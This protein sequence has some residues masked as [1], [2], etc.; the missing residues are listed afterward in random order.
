MSDN[1]PWY[2]ELI[3]KYPKLFRNLQY[4][5]CQEGWKT[6][7]NNLCWVL[8]NHLTED[9]PTELQDDIYATQVKQKFGSLR[10][11]MSHE[12]PFVKGAVYLAEKQSK[13]TCEI[14]GNL[15]SVRTIRSY[16]TA[17]CDKHYEEAKGK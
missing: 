3:R 2:E 5:E 14:C 12:T 11:Y 8:E 15:G 16:L 7:L 10:F 1:E 9:L 13:Y 17:L 4:L 6:L